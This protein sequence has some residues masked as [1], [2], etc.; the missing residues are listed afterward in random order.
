M[1]S[2]FHGNCWSV[3]SLLWFLCHVADVSFD[4]LKECTVTIFRVTSTLKYLGRSKCVSYMGKMV[5]IWPITVI[6]HSSDWPDFLHLLPNN[7]HNCFFATTS[8]TKW[9]WF[10][11]PK[12]AGSTFLQ[13]ITTHIDNTTQKPK[14]R[15]NA[16]ISFSC[17]FLPLDAVVKHEGYNVQHLIHE[18]H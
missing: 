4:V 11:H 16:S 5:E 18:S 8:A 2:G 10:S 1:F 13:Y 14:R 7:W 17:L 3:V 9:K 12:D 15:P 6:P